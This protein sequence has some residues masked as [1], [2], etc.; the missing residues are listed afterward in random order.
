[1]LHREAR[2][3]SN[4]VRFREEVQRI[5]LAEKSY[6]TSTDKNDFSPSGMTFFRSIAVIC[7]VGLTKR[8]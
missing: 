6:Q 4:R 3:T 1:L 5:Q 2:L 8:N 7:D